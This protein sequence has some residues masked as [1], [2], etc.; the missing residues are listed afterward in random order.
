MSRTSGHRPRARDLFG[1]LPDRSW[2]AP[3]LSVA[4]LALVAAERL[5]QFE[6]EVWLRFQATAPILA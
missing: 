1:L 6:V 2:L 3:G 4:G 5:D